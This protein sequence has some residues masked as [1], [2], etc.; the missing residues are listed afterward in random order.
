MTAAASVAGAILVPAALARLQRGG[1]AGDLA[2]QDV[3]SLL[4]VH[5]NC[6]D[7]NF[8]PVSELGCDTALKSG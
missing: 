8:F 6:H 1:Y 5:W 2:P 4:Q 3:A 7:S